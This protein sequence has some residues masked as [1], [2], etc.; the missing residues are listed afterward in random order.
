MF[1][2]LELWLIAGF[3]YFDTEYEAFKAWAETY[4]DNCSLLIDTYN[5]LKSGLPNA[6][7]I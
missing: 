6:I 5:V 4:P 1:L 7:S 2:Q 3:N